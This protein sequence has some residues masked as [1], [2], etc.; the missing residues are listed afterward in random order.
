MAGRGE[1]DDLKPID[2]ATLGVVSESPGR[3]ESERTD[4]L[5]NTGLA[6]RTRSAGAKAYGSLE[7]WLARED[8]PTGL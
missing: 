5:E 7:T 8:T 1:S 6:G 4:G 2:E 3:S